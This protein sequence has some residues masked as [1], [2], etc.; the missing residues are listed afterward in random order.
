MA[1]KVT[2]GYYEGVFYGSAIDENSWDGYEA[3]SRE[4]FTMLEAQCKL[5]PYDGDYEAARA[6]AICAMAEQMQNFDFVA[7]G[8]GGIASASI[9]SVSVSGG[10]AA[11]VIDVS[12]RGRGSTLLKCVQTYFNV[13]TGLR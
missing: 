13:F 3:R 2:Y 6:N 7:N 4:S 11:D 8:T 10:R 9:G 1:E 5:V 12:E